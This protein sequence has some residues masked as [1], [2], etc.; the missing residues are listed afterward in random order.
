MSAT[1]NLWHGCHKISPGC[2]HC[3][4]Y[5]M[6][7]AHDR[8]GGRVYRTKSFDLPVRR[9]RDHAYK[10]P[11]GELVYT[12]FTSDFFLEDADSWRPEAWRMIRE[13]QDLQF[14]FITKRIHRFYDCIPDDWGRGYPHVHIG[15]T[16]ENRERA[17]FRLPIFREAPIAEKSIIC[18]PLLEELDLSAYLGPWVRQVIA[19]GE[20]GQE[21]RECDYRWIL[22]L[23]RQCES[24]RVDFHFKQTGARL[25]KDG[26]LYR[27]PRRHQHAQ[28]R[29]AGIDLSFS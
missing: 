15:C 28:A 9:G 26:R 8:D 21:A 3:Y 2:A 25:R 14:L 27:I 29:K 5:R 20:S 1:W 12:C 6:D 22:A 10:I 18:E 24:A 4:V 11:S 7:S 23:R 16:V 13:R 17:A 19:G